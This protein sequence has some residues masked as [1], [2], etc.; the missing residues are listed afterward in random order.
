MILDIPAEEIVNREFFVTSHV[1][2]NV[3]EGDQFH[4]VA[5]HLAAVGGGEIRRCPVY[6][7][8]C[9]YDRLHIPRVAWVALRAI[10]R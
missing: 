4:V 8:D 10:L 2:R 6:D 9:Q 5:F 3:E 1:W 7:H